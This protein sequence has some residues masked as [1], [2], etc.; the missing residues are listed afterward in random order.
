MVSDTPFTVV[1]FMGVINDGFGMDNVVYNN[2]P[3]PSTFALVS[4]GLAATALR[5]RRRLH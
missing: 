4:L 1:T 5:A 2:V 3:E